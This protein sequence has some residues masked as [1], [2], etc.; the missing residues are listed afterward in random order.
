MK[1]GLGWLQRK[2]H[3]GYFGYNFRFI[4]NHGMAWWWKSCHYQL[5][6]KATPFLEILLFAFI[7]FESQGLGEA[8]PS[9][10]VGTPDY[11]SPN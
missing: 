4:G 10:L 11:N 1:I 5:D 3:F 9:A 2:E 7:G 6:K 8:F